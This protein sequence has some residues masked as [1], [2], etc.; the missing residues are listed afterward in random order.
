MTTRIQTKSFKAGGA[1]S[2]YRIVKSGANDGEVLQAAA[3]A[4]FLMGVVDQPSGVA[5][6]D[7]VDV[8][9]QGIVEIEFAG[10]VTRGGPVTSDA[11]GK[12]VAA[13]PGAGTNNR[14]IGFA[15]NTQAAGDIGDVL[16]SQH[17]MQG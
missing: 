11:N 5:S 10:V 6:G 12:A 1:I 9:L 7:R 15:M 4:D 16:L 2:N 3:A 14:V 8:V 17:T 13:A